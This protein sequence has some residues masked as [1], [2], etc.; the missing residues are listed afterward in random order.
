MVAFSD[1]LVNFWTGDTL[2]AVL[3]R[4]RRIN[5]GATDCSLPMAYAEQAGIDVDAFIIL[6]DGETCK[7]P[8]PS[9]PPSPLLCTF[10]SNVL[11]SES[12]TWARNISLFTS[13]PPPPPPLPS[14]RTP[15]QSHALVC[16]STA[17]NRHR[18]SFA[19]GK[20]YL[21]SHG[22]KAISRRCLFL[23]C[24][25]GR[26]EHACGTLRQYRA[27]RS[28]GEG[29]QPAKLLVCAFSSTGFTIADPAD[30]GML[31]SKPFVP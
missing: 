27:S 25:A 17:M 10:H 7:S 13:P 26:G 11:A 16:K 21:P 8:S 31:V 6:T 28:L 3:E 29:R 20:E 15:I 1:K 18:T 24:F 4:G 30:A 2:E 23:I 9:L 14:S 12:P 22:F 19:I 5:F